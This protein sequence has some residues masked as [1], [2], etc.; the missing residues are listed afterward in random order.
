MQQRASFVAQMQMQNDTTLVRA[1]K[2]PGS[3]LQTASG[4]VPASSSGPANG[5]VQ[6]VSA[7]VL[8]QAAKIMTRAMGPIAK[9]MV[10]KAAARANS[11][12]QLVAL[13]AEEIPAGPQRAQLLLELSQ[14][15]ASVK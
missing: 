5:S 8:D 3:V 1:A 11:A 13:L 4:A 14:A 7:A 9:I 12:E 6:P 2:Q 15:A 10:K